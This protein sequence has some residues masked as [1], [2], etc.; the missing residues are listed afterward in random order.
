VKQVL[1]ACTHNAGRSQM[2]A[3]F[4]NA[5]ADP[6]KAHAESAGTQ[7]GDRVHPEVLAAMKE[8]GIDLSGVK[9]RKL[10]QE[11]A[12]SADMLITMGCEEACPVVPGLVPVDWPLPDPKGQPIETVREIRDEVRG[13]VKELIDEEGWRAAG[14]SSST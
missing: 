9:P 11:L 2:A 4:F 14:T 13:R 5:L 6:S 8:A 7:P 12:E 3:A 1:F 10:T